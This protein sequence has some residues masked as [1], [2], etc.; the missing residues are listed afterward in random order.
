MTGYGNSF[1]STKVDPVSV[2][3]ITVWQSVT[4]FFPGGAC[5]ASP[6]D[7]YPVGYLFPA[8]TPISAKDGVPGGEAVIGGTA[9]EGLLYEDVRMGSNGCTFTIVTQGQLLYDRVDVTITAAQ[10]KALFG[11]IT[12]VKGV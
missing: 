3:R 9:P 8:G 1:N 6:T 4:D 11:R 12:M 2:S 5:L 7:A 10:E